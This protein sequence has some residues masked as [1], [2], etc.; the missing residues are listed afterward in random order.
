VGVV[1]PKTSLST[2]V[3]PQTGVNPQKTLT[4]SWSIFPA[5]I[6]QVDWEVA[7]EPEALEWKKKYA[8]CFNLTE[9]LKASAP[10]N[11]YKDY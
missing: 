4:T 10:P 9:T 7:A 11:K 8:K 3:D 5:P 2:G 1:Q 6:L